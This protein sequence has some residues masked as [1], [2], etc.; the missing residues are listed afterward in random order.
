VDELSP[1]ALG[2]GPV[3]VGS[4]TATAAGADGAFSVAAT[5]SETAA[6]GGGDGAGGTPRSGG[7]K[8]VRAASSN[9]NLGGGGGDGSGLPWE[10]LRDAAKRGDNVTFAALVSCS[11]SPSAG[12]DL[13]Y[14]DGCTEGLLRAKSKELTEAAGE[15][16]RV[17]ALRDDLLARVGAMAESASAR[18]AVAAAAATT[19]PGAAADAALA[20]GLAQIR[21]VADDG[22][23]VNGAPPPTALV[24]TATLSARSRSYR[25]LALAAEAEE[26]L[27]ALAAAHTAAAAQAARA[28][29]DEEAALRDEIASLRARLAAADTEARRLR[30]LQRSTDVLE[31]KLWA[32]QRAVADTLRRGHAALAG[33]RDREA[34]GRE[35][36]SRLRLLSVHHDAFFIWHR[37]PFVTING[38]RLGRLP[39]Q[40][41]R[42]RARSGWWR[43][44]VLLRFSRASVAPPRARYSP[45]PTLT[46]CLHARPARAAR[47]VARDQ[48]GAGAG[49]HAAGAGGG[50]RGARLLAVRRADGAV[51]RRTAASCTG[52]LRVPPVCAH[53]PT[54]FLRPPTRAVCVSYRAA[55]AW[56]RWGRSR[57]W[58]PAA[59]RAAAPRWAARP[60]ATTRACTSCSMT[61]AT[62]G[63]AGSRRRSRRC[64]CASR[65]WATLPRAWTARSG[66]RTPSARA[67]TR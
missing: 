53:T 45:F 6:D 56:C 62:L 59:A 34:R 47:G 38:C 20:H 51:S 44:A 36:L 65:S 5:S 61:A 29:A 39:G 49:G 19:A 30:A 58:R 25:H 67:A 52:P 12:V 37:G 46:R 35:L 18:Q 4:G 64:S 63:S 60:A 24:S 7:G 54:A 11:A 40:V 15:R 2:D 27:T 28:L 17:L 13:P 57:A 8:L 43:D 33:Y 1:D 31:S 26:A 21:L 55:T 3:S 16:D 41:V 23:D 9:T 10:A 66:C 42:A 48:R 22:S 50:T 14:C 32:E